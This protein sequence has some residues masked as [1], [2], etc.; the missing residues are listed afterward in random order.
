MGEVMGSRPTRCMYNLPNKK[1][2]KK[3][4][5]KKN[6]KLAMLGLSPGWSISRSYG[7]I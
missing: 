7:C 4:K 1:K 5:K 3:K 6:I 2:K